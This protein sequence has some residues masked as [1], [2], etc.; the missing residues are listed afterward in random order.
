MVQLSL[1]KRPPHAGTKLAAGGTAS[2]FCLCFVKA[3]PMVEKVVS[4]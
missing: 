1:F 3:T 4:C 2:L